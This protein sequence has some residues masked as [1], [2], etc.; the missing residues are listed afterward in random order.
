MDKNTKSLLTIVVIFGAIY[1]LG[2]GQIPSFGPQAVTTAGA[3]QTIDGVTVF[4]GTPTLEW[5]ASN[6]YTGEEVEL[7]WDAYRVTI[8]GITKDYGA[9][10]TANASIGDSFQVC[11]LPNSTYYAA[12]E[13]GVISSTVTK[14]NLELIQIG[15]ASAYF[16]NDSENST[17]RNSSSA[18]DTLD[19]GDTDTPTYC[20]S[21]GTALASFG[22]GAFLV[23]FDHNSAELAGP[24]VWSAGTR[25][26]T[27]IPG[28]YVADSNVGSAKVGYVVSQRLTTGDSVCGILTVTNGATDPVKQSDIKANVYDRFGYRHTTTDALG[29][30]YAGETTGADTNSATNIGD[31]YYFT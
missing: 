24:P 12:C 25:N 21:G 7:A 1:M 29:F 22:D 26:D 16:N 15:S 17:T 13:T 8:G 28:T 27:V 18:Q 20:V 6:A 10:D 19:A 14:V 4:T 9:S 30:G 31:Y 2:G 3:G 11:T 5:Y 23:V